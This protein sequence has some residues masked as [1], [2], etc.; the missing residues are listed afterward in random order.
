M[1]PFTRSLLGLALPLVLLTT[2]LTAVAQV[3]CINDDDCP[4]AECGG[5]VC[6]WLAEGNTCMPPGS[7]PEGQDGWCETDLDCKCRDQGA[8]CAAARCTFVVSR[9]GSGGSGGGGSSTGGASGG[10]TVEAT[11][12]G[13]DGGCALSA[14]ISEAPAPWIGAAALLLLFG[15]RRR[16]AR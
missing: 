8:T 12:S 15:A 3:E 16:G 5:E 4:G 14:P 2:T 7:M 11:G 10:G 1:K 9:N 13:D 6:Q